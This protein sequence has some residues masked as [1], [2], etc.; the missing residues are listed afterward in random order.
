MAEGYHG[1]GCGALNETAPCSCSQEISYRD[2][3]TPEQYLSRRKARVHDLGLKLV[4]GVDI[5]DALGRHDEIVAR[6][7]AQAAQAL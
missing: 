5:T 4:E 7:K 2:V 1:L 6:L 3:E